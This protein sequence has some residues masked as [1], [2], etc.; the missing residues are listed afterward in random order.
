MSKKRKAVRRDGYYNAFLGQGT[1]RYDPYKAYRYDGAPMTDQEAED[2][3]SYNGIARKIITAPANEAVR[4]DFTLRA[5]ETV[6]DET[7]DVL[8]V[9]EDLEWKPK[10][11]EALTWNRLF[12]GALLVFIADD[13]GDLTEP[14]QDS[15]MK[16]LAAV[17]VYD[18][19]S[20]SYAQTY[21]DG[22][23]MGEPEIYTVQNEM[24]GS[25]DV[26]ESRCLRLTGEEV[27]NRMRQQRDGWGGRVFETIRA[28]LTH[29][30]SSMDYSLQALTRMSQSLL[31]LAGLS[32]MLA[33]EE[34][35]MAV[36]KRLDLI[37]MVRNMMNTIALDQDDEYDI[38]T[39]PLSG[40]P[41]LVQEFQV[42]LCAASD[43]P[44]TVLFGRSPGGLNATGVS[45]LENYYNMIDRIRQRT[46]RPILSRM[47]QMLDV[48]GQVHLPP[49]YTLVFDPLWNPSK[50]EAAETAFV[51]AQTREKDAATAAAIGFCGRWLVD[52]DGNGVPDEAE[53]DNRPYPPYLAAQDKEKGGE[54]NEDL[55]KCRV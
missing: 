47:I 13:N 5:G 22:P 25:F 36:R 12:G 19:P 10:L 30:G 2:L 9:M 8:S 29:Y 45:D 23:R 37:D 42:A 15:R 6:L 54:N 27:S 1:R 26:H 24:G 51:E 55:K 32:G 4:P 40:I 31:K 20:V 34:G 43:I 53:K 16:G 28:D 48:S 17:K 50:K 11:S 46:L 44:M 14:F 18:A 21:M 49:E 41:E 33:T 35:E 38:R 39:I 7:K 3:F 52:Q